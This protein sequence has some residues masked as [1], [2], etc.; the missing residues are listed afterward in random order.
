MRATKRLAAKLVE[1]AP[2][3]KHADGGGLSLIVKASG[4]RSWVV[5]ATADGKQRDIGIGGYPDVSLADAS[6]RAA[7]LRAHA[8][9]GDDPV[10]ASRRSGIPTFAAAARIV[11]EMNLPRWR[12]EQAAREWLASLERYAFESLGDVPLHRIQR[13]DVLSVLLPV[14]TVK[15]ET[16]R[17]V[18]QRVRKVLE[19]GTAHGWIDVN[20]AGEVINGALPSMTKTKNH[21]RALSYVDV[22]AAL[23]TIGGSQASLAS[24]LCLRLLILTAT[25]SGEARG[26]RWEE[27]DLPGATWT[28]PADR[29]KANGEHRVPLSRQALGVLEEAA[30]LRDGSGLVFPSPL[31]AGQ[32]LSWE[33]LLKVLRTAGIDSTAHGFRSSFKTWCIEQTSVPWAVGEA[34]LAHVIGNSV[35]AAYVRSDLFEQRRQ[36]MQDWADYVGACSRASPANRLPHPLDE[37]RQVS[38]R[39]SPSCNDHRGGEQHRGSQPQKWRR[40]A[41]NV[42]GDSPQ[43]LR[44]QFRCAR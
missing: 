25:R 11:H 30:E 44:Q 13:A 21:Q 34:A 18:R 40:R 22:P 27:F 39:F 1:H 14:W 42:P 32:P 35:E 4:A 9:G 33:A 43:R 8:A 15:P 2:R 36:L 41:P 23:R 38:E 7:E 12:N 10:T 3:G 17:R 16:A 24:K 20:P 28:I 31:R 19:Y 26:A 37:L 5:R 29:M 6:L